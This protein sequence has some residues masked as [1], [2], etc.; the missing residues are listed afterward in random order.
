MVKS[1]ERVNFLGGGHPKKW[2]LV[3]GHVKKLVSWG[4]VMQFFHDASQIP[5]A[6]T[7][8]IKNE[9]SLMAEFCL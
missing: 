1:W 9:R 5:P 3:G 8:L 2:L 4:V 6:P 7:S